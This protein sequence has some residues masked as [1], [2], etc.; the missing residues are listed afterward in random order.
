MPGQYVND[1]GT[2]EFVDVTIALNASLS[3]AVDLG[4]RTACA[5]QVPA[6]TAWTDADLTFEGSFDGVTYGPV[7]VDNYYTEYVID[8]PATASLDSDIVPLTLPIFACL[9]YL[10]VRS[11]TAASAVNQAAARTIRIAYRPV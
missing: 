10:K 11:G 1:V 9:R 4:G 2:K 7:R 8:L 6:A 3:A 5:I